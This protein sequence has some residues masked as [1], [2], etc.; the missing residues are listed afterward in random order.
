LEGA[1]A[2]RQIVAELGAIHSLV[3]V[4]VAAGITMV[5]VVLAPLV[6]GMLGE[7]LV[8]LIHMVVVVVALGKLVER[9]T[10]QQIPVRAAMD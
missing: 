6:K 2:A 8:Q 4:V 7:H 1:G 10:M 9:I 3:V 5:Q